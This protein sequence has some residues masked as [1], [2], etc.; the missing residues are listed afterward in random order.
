MK[1]KA[2]FSLRL[3]AYEILFNLMISLSFIDEDKFDQE[4]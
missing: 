2:K 4:D 3:E 1:I